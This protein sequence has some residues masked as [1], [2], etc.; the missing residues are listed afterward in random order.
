[1]DGDPV[2]LNSLPA[3]AC[4][5]AYECS[6]T[7]AIFD[8]Y[9]KPLYVGSELDARFAELAK[10]RVARHPLRYYVWLPTLRI[11]DMWLRPRTEMLPL[12]SH[13]WAFS[14]DLHDGLLATA[15]GVL[16]LLFVGAAVMALVRGPRPRYLGVML[17]FVV[18]RSAFLGTLENP[19]PRYTLEC[20]PVVLVLAAGWV[21][22]WGRSRSG[23]G[24]LSA[25][26]G[27]KHCTS[28]RVEYAFRRTQAQPLTF[29]L[30]SR[31]DE[32]APADEEPRDLQFAGR[33]MNSAA[34]ASMYA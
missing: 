28:T 21:S 5:T 27:R 24:R 19:E 25:A 10:Q 22:G 6:E 33:A 31:A 34:C 1:M 14:D 13:W 16:N 17:V 12:D 7:R 30:S 9:N 11:V 29:C 18:L 26:P 4:D 8:E 20:F 2:D 23:T 3:R 15:W 32:S